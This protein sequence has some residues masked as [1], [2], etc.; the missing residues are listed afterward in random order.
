MVG[1]VQ[2]A[3]AFLGVYGTVA[4]LFVVVVGLDN[5]FTQECLYAFCDRI[6]FFFLLFDG[7]ADPVV[8][9]QC[10]SGCRTEEPFDDVGCE[11]GDYRFN[12]VSLPFC[13][14]KSFAGNTHCWER[15][16]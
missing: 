14:N 2:S 4:F 16:A 12:E 10:E 1:L 7:A 11:I 3:D 5:I 9:E 6:I 15:P 8:A 13:V